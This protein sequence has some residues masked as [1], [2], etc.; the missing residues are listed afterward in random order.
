M[1][2]DGTVLIELAHYKMP[3]GKYKDQYLIDIPEYYYIWFQQKGFP[4]G[5]LGSMMKQMCEI[6]ING[7]EELIYTI[8]RDFKK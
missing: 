5:K 3:F 6:K 2:L 8:R 7:L 1:E 4:E